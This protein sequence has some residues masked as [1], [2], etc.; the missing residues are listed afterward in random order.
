MVKMRHNCATVVAVQPRRL[1]G[2]GFY[3]YVG[4]QQDERNAIILNVLDQK[5][6]QESRALLCIGIDLDHPAVPY[7]VLAVRQSPNLFDELQ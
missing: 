3:P 5:E 4:L 6:A 1:F 7:A 2:V